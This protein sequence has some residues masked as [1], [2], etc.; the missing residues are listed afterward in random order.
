MIGNRGMSGAT[1]YGRSSVC[2]AAGHLAKVFSRIRSRISAVQYQSEGDTAADGLEPWTA[3]LPMHG[4]TNDICGGSPTPKVLTE[5]ELGDDLSTQ[6]DSART[7]DVVRSE[8]VVRTHTPKAPVDSPLRTTINDSDAHVSVSL[9]GVKALREIRRESTKRLPWR[10][11][12]KPQ[13]GMSGLFPRLTSSL[14]TQS[15]NPQV[16]KDGDVASS[17]PLIGAEK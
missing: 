10:R 17:F 2:L 14:G 1:W 8:D 16:A 3:P 15:S 4:S 11:P 6:G 7:E 12:D 13:P 5:T 9:S